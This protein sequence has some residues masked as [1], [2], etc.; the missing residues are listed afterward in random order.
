M[1]RRA[2]T[3]P[4]QRRGVPCEM[5]WRSPRARR[6]GS[7]SKMSIRSSP[8]GSAT[9]SL[10]TVTQK[11][12]RRRGFA[13]EPAA[14][15]DR[16][17]QSF[18]HQAADNGTDRQPGELAQLDRR[19][20]DVDR[21]RREQRSGTER[22]QQPKHE[23]RRLPEP[24]SQCA[25]SPSGAA[26]NTPTMNA[27]TTTPTLSC[28]HE[29]TPEVTAI[30]RRGRHHECCSVAWPATTEQARTMMPVELSI[31]RQLRPAAPAAV[32]HLGARSGSRE[33]APFGS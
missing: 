5:P 20:D 26:D 30:E 11:G 3:G 18:E 4:R 22:G 32:R 16:P 10:F 29:P 15:V 33:R 6:S 24:G 8:P 21:H 25:P 17:V 12:D 1:D 2:G 9:A 31:R 7:P 13:E 23:V 19:G 28:F 27:P 14:D